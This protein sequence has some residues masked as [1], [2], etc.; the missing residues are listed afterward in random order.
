MKTTEQIIRNFTE[1]LLQEGC[2]QPSSEKVDRF[3]KENDI[4]VVNHK[5]EVNG[6]SFVVK[7]LLFN[8]KFQKAFLTISKDN[9]R[10]EVEITKENAYAN[11]IPALKQVGVDLLADEYVSLLGDDLFN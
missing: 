10:K 11:Y 8:G 7:S 6:Q 1:T 9:Q 2:I 4:N 5:K 3:I